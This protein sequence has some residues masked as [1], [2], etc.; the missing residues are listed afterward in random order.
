MLPVCTTNWEELWIKGNLCILSASY[1]LIQKIFNV[2]K[3]PPSAGYQ[4]RH[5]ESVLN[6]TD[7]SCSVL[8]NLNS[9]REKTDI[10]QKCD[11][12]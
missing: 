10:N 9:S 5:W 2:F 12:Y 11:K 4:S 3:L 6:V 7:K 1:S 8:M